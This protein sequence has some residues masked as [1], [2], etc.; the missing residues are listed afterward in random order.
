[1]VYESN[2]PLI[3]KNEI[4]TWPLKSKNLDELAKI[5]L[6]LDDPLTEEHICYFDSNTN[7]TS[8]IEYLKD[9]SSLET[10]SVMW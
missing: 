4:K 5:Y 10:F 6:E 1:M 9:Q 3:E 8:L 2:I 7:H